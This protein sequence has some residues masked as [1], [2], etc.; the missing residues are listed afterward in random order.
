MSAGGL[1]YSGITNYGKVILPSAESW[2][3]NN[4]I[5]RD[6]PK[7]IMTRKIDKVGETSSI[8]EMVDDSSD[9]ACEAIQVYARGVNP[10]VSVSYS[11]YGNNGGQ[12]Q[13]G[14]IAGLNS[15]GG[16]QAKL[17][18]TIMN[19]GAF[20]PPIR[21]QEDLLPLSRQHRISTTAFTKPGFADFSR[22]LRTCGTAENTKEVFTEKLVTSVRPTAVYKIDKPMER[23]YEVKNAVQ[24]VIKNTVNSGMRS[25][26][27]TQQTVIEPTKEVK[28]IPLHSN[29]TTNISDRTRFVN[30]TNNM[31]TDR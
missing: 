27:I 30:D 14:H 10:S 2:G 5:L 8:T 6:P 15:G 28:D 25:M 29:A 1:S 17:P 16:L 19:D 3:T 24:N 13:S 12:G 23:P 26:D 11:N 18:F 31:A 21:R 7:S 4:N 20:R 22:K 9:R